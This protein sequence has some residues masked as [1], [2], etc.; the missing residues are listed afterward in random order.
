MVER[1]RAPPYTPMTLHPLKASVVTLPLSLGLIL[2]A[3]YC[4][5]HNNTQSVQQADQK[6][7][8]RFKSNNWVSD[9]KTVHD[10]ASKPQAV[11]PVQGTVVTRQ[12]FDRLESRFDR[13]KT[14]LLSNP[15]RPK[16][17]TKGPTKE[18][19]IR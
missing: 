12:D 17:S 10:L 19:P 18:P 14:I 4:G 2:T 7:L 6:L 16:N 13:L 11:Q 1:D 15:S 5:Y 3:G 8:D 9:D